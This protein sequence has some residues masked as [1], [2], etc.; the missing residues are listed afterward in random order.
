LDLGPDPPNSPNPTTAQINFNSLAGNLAP[1]TLQLLGL[2]SGHHV[3]VLVDGG[4]THNFIQEDLVQRIGLPTQ[5]TTPL[6]V[7]V[8]NGQHLACSRWCP[9]VNLTIQ[10]FTCDV[11]LYVL[12]TVGANIVLCVQ[13]LKT[14]VP[15]LT[16]YSLMTMK[17][18]YDQRL[19]E[20]RGDT[21]LTINMLTPPQL[22]RFL[23]H[24]E[25]A[26]CFHIAV[27]TEASPDETPP[28]LDPHIKTLIDHFG[29]LFQPPTSLSPARITNHHIHL[30]PQ[31][32]P[33]N[34]RPTGTP[35]TRNRRLNFKW[36]QCCRRA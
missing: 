35:I 5:D 2:A 32:T 22:R 23:K 12:P 16:D 6:R 33:V 36:N 11:D 25:H 13:W 27:L 26:S 18:F 10:D 1:K 17:F 30:L 31:A 7:L 34:V 19:I 29:T 8:G 24:N 28:P 21:D 20:L 3:V 14:L 15:V 4:N 9:R